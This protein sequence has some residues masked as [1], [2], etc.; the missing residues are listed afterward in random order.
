MNIH[1]FSL[2]IAFIGQKSIHLLQDVHLFKSM[3]N[4]HV[5][6]WLAFFLESCI[7]GTACN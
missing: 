6:Y 1:P 5:N 2:S 4:L 7:I 3:L